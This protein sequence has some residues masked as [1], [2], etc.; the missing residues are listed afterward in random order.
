MCSPLLIYD[1][2]GALFKLGQHRQQRAAL[3]A[4][5]RQ[6]GC[7]VREAGFQRALLKKLSP[8]PAS[9][10]EGSLTIKVARLGE[11]IRDVSTSLNMTRRAHSLLDRACPGKS[12]G[13]D[14]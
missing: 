13:L 5:Y 12:E 3:K 1:R 6:A 10:A 14:E 2:H 11:M 7:S 8:D 9:A 4:W